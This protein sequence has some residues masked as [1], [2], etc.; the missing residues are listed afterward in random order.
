MTMHMTIPRTFRADI[1]F[2]DVIRRQSRPTWPPPTAQSLCSRP[3][4]TCNTRKKLNCRV[5][6]W[7]A[8]ILG[9]CSCGARVAHKETEERDLNMTLQ[10]W[11]DSI[12]SQMLR[13]RRAAS[14]KGE[15]RAEARLI[16][17]GADRRASVCNLL[18][19][20][21]TAAERGRHYPPCQALQRVQIPGHTCAWW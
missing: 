6:D 11:K 21:H 17:E 10:R 4:H 12:P 9:R 16:V 18:C 8:Q 15:S 5:S 1:A 19:T 13:A 2:A 3:T 7:H 20:L 14:K